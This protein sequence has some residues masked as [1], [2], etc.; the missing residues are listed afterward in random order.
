MTDFVVNGKFWPQK[1]EQ[2]L[3]IKKAK[4]APADCKTFKVATIV[5][6]KRAI[7]DYRIDPNVQDL[8]LADIWNMNSV[9]H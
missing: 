5:N 9:V 1:I 6:K 8:I 3:R 7:V 4:I 2:L